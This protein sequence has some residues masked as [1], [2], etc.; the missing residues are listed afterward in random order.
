MQSYAFDVVVEITSSNRLG[1]LGTGCNVDGILKGL[2]SLNEFSI[3]FG[4]KCV[5]LPLLVLSIWVPARAILHCVDMLKQARRSGSGVSLEGCDE[6][7]CTKVEVMREK[8]PEGV[9]RGRVE[10]AMNMNVAAGSDPPVFL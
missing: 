10:N 4:C 2:D 7:L 1:F 3:L 8:D 5:L 9:I 6:D